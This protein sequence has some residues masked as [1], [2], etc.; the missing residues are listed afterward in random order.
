MTPL[1]V[2]AQF[3]VNFLVGERISVDE[4]HSI[5]WEL[6][7]FKEGQTLRVTV[8][9]FLDNGEVNGPVDFV[10]RP[11]R[12]T[13]PGVGQAEVQDECEPPPVIYLP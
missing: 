6:R 11:P 13:L 9:E 2:N 10:M 5:E 8:K 3:D 4:D 7:A 1:L 12:F